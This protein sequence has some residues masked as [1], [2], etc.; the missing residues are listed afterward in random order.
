MPELLVSS[1]L[2][3]LALQLPAPLNKP[4]EASWPL[5]FEKQLTPEAAAN[6]Q[7]PLQ[8]RLSLSLPLD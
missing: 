3:G 8:E 5:R 2:Q 4:A 1:S 7:A 6:S